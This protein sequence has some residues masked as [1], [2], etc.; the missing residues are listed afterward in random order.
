MFFLYFHSSHH[1]GDSPY[2]F[3]DYINSSLTCDSFE[4]EGW[5]E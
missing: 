4:G 2:L 3:F 1:P 5:H